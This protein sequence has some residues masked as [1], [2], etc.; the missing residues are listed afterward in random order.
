MAMLDVTPIHLTEGMNSKRRLFHYFL[1]V[2]SPVAVYDITRA[3]TYIHDHRV[4]ADYKMYYYFKCGKCDR[5]QLKILRGTF[6]LVLQTM[7]F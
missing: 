1:T 3:R 5:I 4:E 2:E 6:Q 7:K